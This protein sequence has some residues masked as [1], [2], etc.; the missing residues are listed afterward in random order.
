MLERHIFT[1]LVLVCRRTG[2]V[3]FLYQYRSKLGVLRRSERA[4]EFTEYKGE[5]FAL[6]DSVDERKRVLTL[7]YTC[8]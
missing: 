8:Q 7:C 2:G 5:M 3:I 4:Q 6:I 1:A